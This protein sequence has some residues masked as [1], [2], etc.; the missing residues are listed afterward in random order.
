MARSR[1]Y[2]L[3]LC[4]KTASLL[5]LGR[6]EEGLR[7]AE[8]AYRLA[9]EQRSDEISTWSA[10]VRAQLA[11]AVGDSEQALR[12]AREAVD[13]AEGTGGVRTRGSAYVTLGDVHL[14]AERWSA[15]RKAIERGMADHGSGAWYARAVAQLAHA[16]IGEGDLERARAAVE[17]ARSLM[18]NRPE[19]FELDGRL[20]HA[21]LL[22]RD[23]GAAAADRI[24][25]ILSDTMRLC[26]E[27]EM[28]HWIPRI[29]RERAELAR[30]RGDD[31][32]RERELREAHR[33][34]TEMGATGHA[35][36]LAGELGL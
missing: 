29:H 10:Q 33:L 1:A 14:E 34:Y 13:R 30:V 18:R 28:G 11:D 31:T 22:L 4:T 27:A 26:E 5:V 21:R 24:E 35:K 3:L 15:A 9:R 25:E 12:D 2:S 6:V 36:R 17:E 20:A 8:E 16:C 32:T 19:R 23:E 7:T